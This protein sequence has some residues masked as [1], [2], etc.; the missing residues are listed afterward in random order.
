M[1][2]YPWDYSEGSGDGNSR[3]TVVQVESSKLLPALIIMS[4][5][6]ALALI[7]AVVAWQKA[8]SAETEARMLEYYVME[9]DGKLMRD[10]VID[11]KQAWSARKSEQEKGK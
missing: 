4:V 1:N 5:L 11:F 8:S 10:G 9:L 7:A 2:S 3:A 6:A